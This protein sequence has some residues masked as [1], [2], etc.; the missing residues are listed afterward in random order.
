LTRHKITLRVKSQSKKDEG[1]ITNTLESRGKNTNVP[2]KPH[3]T[4]S[5]DMPIKNLSIIEENVLLR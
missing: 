1:K 2:K 4:P 3:H 5:L